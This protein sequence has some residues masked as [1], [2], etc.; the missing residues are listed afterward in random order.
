MQNANLKWREH[1]DKDPAYCKRAC[2]WTPYRCGRDYDC[3]CH[4]QE[5]DK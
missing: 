3:G 4:Q 2:C 1:V 5:I